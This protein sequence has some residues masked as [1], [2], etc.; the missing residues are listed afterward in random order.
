MN[1]LF[2]Y[3][4]LRLIPTVFLAL[5]AAAFGLASRLLPRPIAGSGVNRAMTQQLEH[6]ARLRDLRNRRSTFAPP[7]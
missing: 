5:L 1:R 3:R 6:R 7:R 2:D 4:R